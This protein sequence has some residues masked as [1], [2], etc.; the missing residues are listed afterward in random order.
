MLIDVFMQ[1]SKEDKGSTSSCYKTKQSK[2]AEK[3]TK[4]GL[5]PCTENIKNTGII[6]NSRN[7]MPPS[8]VLFLPDTWSQKC[9]Y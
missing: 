9:T 1:K 6:R 2:Q 4:Q 3:Q 5:P 8:I 7:T